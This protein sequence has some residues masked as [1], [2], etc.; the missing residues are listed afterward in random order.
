[1]AVLVIAFSAGPL[2]ASGPVVFQRDGTYFHSVVASLA[3]Q[4]AQPG[5]ESSDS[6]ETPKLTY[7]GGAALTGLAAYFIASSGGGDPA[8]GFPNAPTNPPGGILIP[9]PDQNSPPLPSGPTGPTGPAGPTLP[10]D[11]PTL[12]GPVTTTPEPVSMTLLATGLAGLSGVQLR[13]R[14]RRG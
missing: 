3:A 2:S 1:M 9:P 14:A 12:G 8:P 5:A 7:M 13:K 6:S 10:G 11:G 4:D